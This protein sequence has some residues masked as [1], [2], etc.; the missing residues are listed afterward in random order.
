MKP[1]D[2]DVSSL[3]EPFRRGSLNLRNRVAMAP[4]TRCFSPN[5]I[6]GADVADYYRRRVEGGVGL[7]ITEGSWIP[8]ASAANEDN[9][10]RFYGEDALAGWSRVLRDV[11]AAGGAIVALTRLARVFDGRRRRRDAIVITETARAAAEAV[12]QA[13]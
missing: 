7:I 13:S 8:H 10:P 6:P 4:M 9:A 5:G 12:R 3:F 11:H 1:A 2:V